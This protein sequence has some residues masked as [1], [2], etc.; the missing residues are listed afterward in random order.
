M[1][2]REIAKDLVQNGADVLDAIL[3]LGWIDS[4]P[5]NV[6]VIHFMD[7]LHCP[8]R[9]AFGDFLKGDNVLRIKGYR[10]LG[11]LGFAHP[12]EFNDVGSDNIEAA[13]DAV[14]AA[15][16]SLITERRTKES[17]AL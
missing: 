17:H 8:L 2:Y 16:W 11:P 9:Y 1:N 10:S 3:G 6:T 12:S 5:Q 7:S 13:Y 4:M 14:N 15:W